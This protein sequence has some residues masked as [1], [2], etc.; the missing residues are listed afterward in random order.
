MRYV[1][2]TIIL[3]L[4][5]LLYSL[6]IFHTPESNQANAT[7]DSTLVSC[8]FPTDIPVASASQAEFDQYS[9]RMFTAL[10]QPVSSSYRGQPD[11]S[12]PL[13]STSKTVW[14]SYKQVDQIFLP[15]AAN[16]GPWNA[17]PADSKTAISAISKVSASIEGTINQPVGG[18]LIDQQKNPTYYQIAANEISYNYIVN[19][20][21]YNKNTL[22]TVS[23][24]NFPNYATE[25]KAS[26]RILT[27]SDSPAR[28]LNIPAE[29]ATFD[30]S[31]KVNGS[32]KVTLGLVGLH[33]I[34]K[35]AGFPQWVWATF[36]QVDNV[37]TT[38]EQ[39][40]YYNAKASAS[41]VNQSPCYNHAVPCTPAPGKNFHTPNPLTRVTP[42]AE[43]T[44]TVNASAQA[45]L[46]ST[47]LQY[48][49]L[50][51]TQRASDPNNPGNPAGSPT[52]AVSANTTMESY[53]QPVSSCMD[54][55]STAS[56]KPGKKSDFSFLF[57]HAQAPSSATACNACL[58][59]ED[60]KKTGFASIELSE[61]HLKAVSNIP[62]R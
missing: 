34:T 41:E 39:P 31:G 28:F 59:T 25:I 33:I 62:A 6:L 60:L 32:E 22:N 55:H 49:E 56:I 46:S 5:G 16:P 24:I 4:C 36:E 47:F 30:D 53:I 23:Q 37:S 52:P 17:P 10:N 7:V 14:R 12:E 54:C 13:G 43:E 11:C 15:G 21:L 9:W 29:V 20:D 42:I 48:Y 1:K 40:S 51:T 57:L 61:S 50:I 26:W 18:W 19:N 2:T 3:A 45:E 38:T 8:Q 27:A 44:A 58:S 35:A